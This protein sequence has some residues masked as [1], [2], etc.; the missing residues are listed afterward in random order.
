MASSP[1]L[2]KSFPCLIQKAHENPKTTFNLGKG[3]GKASLKFALDFLPHFC[4]ALSQNSHSVDD[5]F[6]PFNECG[7]CSPALPN[8]SRDLDG[9]QSPIQ[10]GQKAGIPLQIHR[11]LMLLLPRVLLLVQKGNY[12]DLTAKRTYYS[13]IL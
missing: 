6:K 12:M 8:L 4:F 3:Q 2:I 10:E 7:S 5:Q 1:L 9:Q 13:M 11:L